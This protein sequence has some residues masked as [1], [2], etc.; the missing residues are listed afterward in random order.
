[1]IIPVS[2]REGH[3]EDS[4]IERWYKSLIKSERSRE[5]RKV[6]LSYIEGDSH[7]V[8]TDRSE[9]RNKKEI[10][11]APIQMVDIVGEIEEVD[12]DSKLDMF[13]GF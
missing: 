3:P 13:G 9:G 12:L 7:I 10:I 2:I 11:E 6:L 8:I 4:K 1:M 5:I